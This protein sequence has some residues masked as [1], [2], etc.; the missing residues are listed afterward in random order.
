VPLCELHGHG[1]DLTRSCLANADELD[2]NVLIRANF[3]I[4]SSVLVRRD[5]L[6]A[7]GPF[8]NATLGEDH[9]LWKDLMRVSPAVFVREPL[10]YWRVDSPD[11]LTQ[12]W[13]T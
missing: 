11:K 13:K 10:V 4:T 7:A 8:N 3:V 12:S 6:F 2:W 9:A 1:R 5:T